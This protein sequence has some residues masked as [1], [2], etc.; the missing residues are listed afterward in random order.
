MTKHAPLIRSDL[1]AFA[2]FT[3]GMHIKNKNMTHHNNIVGKQIRNTILK[4]S[5]KPLLNC[6]LTKWFIF[7]IGVFVF[8]SRYKTADYAI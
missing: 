5:S 1:H 2:Q 6:G 4:K 8:L 7:Q 3:P